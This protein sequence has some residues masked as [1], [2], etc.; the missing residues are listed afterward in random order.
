MLGFGTEERLSIEFTQTEQA[1]NSC[2]SIRPTECST[3][4]I[5]QYRWLCVRRPCEREAAEMGGPG[6]GL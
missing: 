2:T 3:L 6:G 4:V 1:Y 5:C